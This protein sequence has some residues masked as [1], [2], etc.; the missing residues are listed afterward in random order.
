MKKYV[1]PFVAVLALILLLFVIFNW[2]RWDTI[3]LVAGA[4]A[5]VAVIIYRALR[6]MK[7]KE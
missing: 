5:V 3:L 2:T 1:T 4:I 6:K 7:K